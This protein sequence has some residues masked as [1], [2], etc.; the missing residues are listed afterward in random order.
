MNIR[1]ATDKDVR[2]FY[3]DVCVPVK[4]LAMGDPVV[5][6]A[7]LAWCDDGVFAVSWIRPGARAYPG[8]MMRL[9]VGVAKMAEEA[10]CAVYA[11]PDENEP[12]AER[13]LEHIGFE[14]KGDRYEYR[15]DLPDRLYARHAKRAARALSADAR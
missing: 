1:P 3:G 15:T 4:M 2:S 6:L 8:A 11:T 13:L 9:G 5:A 12:T 14:R 7:G 10:G